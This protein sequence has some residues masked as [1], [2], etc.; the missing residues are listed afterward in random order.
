[1]H[2]LLDECVPRPLRRELFEHFVQTVQEMGWAEKQ[3]GELFALIK[4]SG[5]YAFLTTDQNLEYQQNLQAA[6]ISIVVLLAHKNTLQALLP[7]APKL[8]SALTQLHP[9]ELIHIRP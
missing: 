1:M 2:V 3:N 8:R 4:Q 6:G 9:G 7:L 5:F